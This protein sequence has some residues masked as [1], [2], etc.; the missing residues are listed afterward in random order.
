MF[1]KLK[2]L[3]HTVNICNYMQNMT[4]VNTFKPWFLYLNSLNMEPLGIK[5][6]P[7]NFIEV[8]V[9]SSHK[10]SNSDMAWRQL[11][12]MWYFSS[13]ITMWYDEKPQPGLLIRQWQEDSHRA[14]NERM[15]VILSLLSL[16][17]CLPDLPPL[18][19]L[20]F[21]FFTHSEPPVRGL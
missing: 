10:C 3:I 4:K 13:N 15:K 9:C 17:H 11:L 8:Y 19:F 21:F 16:C 14:K 5:N 6:V 7:L 20:V 2:K 1:K 18:L 12:N